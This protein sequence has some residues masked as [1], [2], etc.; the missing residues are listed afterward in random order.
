MAATKTK[1][2]TK[3]ERMRR[4]RA[5]IECL[6]PGG[7]MLTI[8][9]PN[10]ERH[11]LSG[12]LPARLKEIAAAGVSG[13]DKAIEEA[14]DGDPEMLTYLDGIVCRSLV[15]PQI[16][17]PVWA[18][19]EPPEDAPDD[20]QPSMV[21]VSGEDP[22]EFLLPVDYQWLLLVAFGER[23]TDGEGKRLWGREPLSRF[24]VF[25]EEHGCAEDCP[26]CQGVQGRFS[27]GG[28]D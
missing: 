15:D 16:D 7:E 23:D 28:A 25:R 2:L 12:G 19:S 5:A 9:P 10:I 24:R 21:L 20:W 27:V 8:Q 17:P 18:L 22:N 11:A 1:D 26:G 4:R 13:I 6:S 14:T 3:K